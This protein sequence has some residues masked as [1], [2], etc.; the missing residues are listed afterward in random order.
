[1]SETNTTIKC[2]QGLPA[3]ASPSWQHG[4]KIPITYNYVT[5]GSWIDGDCAHT[6]SKVTRNLTSVEVA[7]FWTC[8]ATMAAN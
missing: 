8:L 4:E 2:I 1:M 6:L 5:E 3:L 7:A